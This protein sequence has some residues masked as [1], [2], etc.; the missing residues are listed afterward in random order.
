MVKQ[1]GI[2]NLL[3]SESCQWNPHI[4]ETIHTISTIPSKLNPPTVDTTGVPL[5]LTLNTIRWINECVFFG[6]HFSS[7]MIKNYQ[8]VIVSTRLKSCQDNRL[9][10]CHYH[11]HFGFN[12]IVIGQFTGRGREES[13]LMAV[14]NQK[15]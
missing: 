15:H 4:K 8:P 5:H 13:S 11:Y 3:I 6:I 14:Y 1:Y 2:R 10:A 9:P 7:K 12:F